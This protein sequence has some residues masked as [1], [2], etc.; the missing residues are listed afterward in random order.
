MIHSW[1]S[2][3]FQNQFK[4]ISLGQFWRIVQVDVALSQFC[5]RFY[6]E[7]YQLEKV[8]ATLLAMCDFENIC[9]NHPILKVLLFSCSNDSYCMTE[10]I[11]PTYS[12]DEERLIIVLYTSGALIIILAILSLLFLCC[13]CC[14]GSYTSKLKR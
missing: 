4:N 5:E 10:C 1:S 14:L 3:W 6:L 7:I 8:E 12:I 2:L 9:D 13:L 11:S